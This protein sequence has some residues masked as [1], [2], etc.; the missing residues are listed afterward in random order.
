MAITINLRVTP[1]Q[2]KSQKDL[3]QQDLNNIRND[4]TR[5]GNE[6]MGTD[7]YWKGEAAKKQRKNYDDSSQKI[8]NM[9]DRLQTYPDRLLKMAGIYETAESQN[10]QTA[11]QLD[12]D[13]HMI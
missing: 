6:I 12:T 11:A 5:I 8:N 1:E 3:I 13:I 9:L 10:S 2:L 7:S 4:I